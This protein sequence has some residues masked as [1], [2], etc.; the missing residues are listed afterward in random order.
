MKLAIST[1][2]FVHVANGQHACVRLP[3]GHVF[4]HKFYLDKPLSVVKLTRHRLK[5]PGMLRCSRVLQNSK[6]QLYHTCMAV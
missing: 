1:C 2:K 6:D 4:S 3:P 5:L